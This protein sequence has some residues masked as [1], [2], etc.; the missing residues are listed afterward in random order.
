MGIK[1]NDAP[2]L[3][4]LRVSCFVPHLFPSRSYTH[5]PALGWEMNVMKSNNNTPTPPFSVLVGEIR[6]SGTKSNDK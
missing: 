5:H 1:K 4:D 6:G 2:F 3:L